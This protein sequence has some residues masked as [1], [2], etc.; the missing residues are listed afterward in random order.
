MSLIVIA[1]VTR[2]LN[3]V[4][5]QGELKMKIF[6]EKPD[7]FHLF[8]MLVAVIMIGSLGILG[9]CSSDDDDPGI[10]SGATVSAFNFDA[11]NTT[12]AAEIAAAAMDF[13]PT[14]NEIGLVMI[15][16]LSTGNPEESPFVNV[17]P[18]TNAPTG[19]TSLSWVDN[20]DGVLS[21][22]DTATLTFD[23][24]DLEGDGETISGTVTFAATS[25]SVVP[26]S[27]L[28]IDVSINLTIKL[29]PDTT[30]V[31]GDFVL[32]ISSADGVNFTNVY[33]AIDALGHAL[34]IT[35]NGTPYFKAGC[36]TVTQTYSI[37]SVHGGMYDLAPSGAIN[38]S[39]GTQ[40]LLSVSQPDCASIG[41][42][43][44]VADSNGS[45]MDMEAITAGLLTLHTF[46][47]NDVEI[48]TVNTSWTA[49]TD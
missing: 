5:T 15:E 31:A 41:A 26:P 30:T 47:V 39:T 33:K 6:T 4:F 10:V 8:P 12:I 46:D 22:G 25:L 49:L 29:D 32:T 1:I 2:C 13:F 27:T 34:T 20:G 44:G 28:G 43:N 7:R 40:R 24:C 18:C 19:S 36:F 16:T 9:A 21:V 14:F 17:I 37:P 23:V 11:N 35:E 45:Y 38:A 48:F 3:T 42:P